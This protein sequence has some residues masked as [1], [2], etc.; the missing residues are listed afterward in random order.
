MY[1]TYIYWTGGRFP[2][3]LGLKKHVRQT[4]VRSAYVKNFVD[5]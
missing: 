4:V 5:Y 1:M 2:S 3:Y